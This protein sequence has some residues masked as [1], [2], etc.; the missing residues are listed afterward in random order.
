MQQPMKLSETNMIL[1]V[2]QNGGSVTPLRESNGKLFKR[3]AIY[4]WNNDGVLIIYVVS[5]YVRV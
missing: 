1:V 2:I 4:I 5:L 3:N